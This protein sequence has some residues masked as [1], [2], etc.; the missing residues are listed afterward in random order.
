MCTIN[1]NV[2]YYYFFYFVVKRIESLQEME[3]GFPNGE[4]SDGL[5]FEKIGRNYGCI[6]QLKA[7]IYSDS[8]AFFRENKVL[9]NKNSNEFFSSTN[10]NSMYRKYRL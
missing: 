3:L 7:A 8:L 10:R 9:I 4:F 5:F 2:F 6:E 1:E